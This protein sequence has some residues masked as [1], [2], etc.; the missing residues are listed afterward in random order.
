MA[1]LPTMRLLIVLC[2][3]FTRRISFL[4]KTLAILT[5]CTYFV[6]ILEAT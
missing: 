2:E 6:L 4:A 1:S 5:L 3:A